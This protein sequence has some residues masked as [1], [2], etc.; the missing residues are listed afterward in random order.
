MRRRGGLREIAA[1]WQRVPVSPEAAAA[2]WPLVVATYSSI[3]L[4]LR[5]PEELADQPLWFVYGDPAAPHAFQLAKQTVYGRKFTL[6]GHDGSTTG[7]MAAVRA[8][9]E[10]FEQEGNYAEV[11]HGPEKLAKR[12][13]VPVVCAADVAKILGKTIQIESDGIHYT[14]HIT[15]VGPTTKVMVGRPLRVPTQ[16][17]NEAHCAP[18]AATAGLGGLGSLGTPDDSLEARLA[19]ATCRALGRI[20]R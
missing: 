2:I 16:P 11:S 20:I 5:N 4:P 18:P 14:R 10:R 12:A 7:K 9:T 3:G 17:F 13:N 15:N 6:S 8:T 19:H 1:G